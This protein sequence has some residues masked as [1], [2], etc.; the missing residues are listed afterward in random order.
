MKQ[1]LFDRTYQG[2]RGAHL[3]CRTSTTI[4]GE[5]QPLNKQISIHP[6]KFAA[7]KTIR[8]GE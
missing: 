2:P 1:T 7:G 8:R 3:N 5:P 6:A 4:K